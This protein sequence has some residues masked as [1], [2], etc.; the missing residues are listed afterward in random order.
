MHEDIQ[1][2]HRHWSIIVDPFSDASYSRSRH[3]LLE[4]PRPCKTGG[5]SVAGQK[6]P[7]WDYRQKEILSSADVTWTFEW[8]GQ[9]SILQWIEIYF[10]VQTRCLL[11]CIQSHLGYSEASG[12]AFR[13]PSRGPVWYLLLLCKSLKSPHFHFSAS[14]MAPNV[15]KWLKFSI[16]HH[17]SLNNQG[18]NQ[19]SN[20]GQF[21]E[22]LFTNKEISLSLQICPKGLSPLSH[23]PPAYR[24]F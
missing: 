11:L 17:R 3:I 24:Y 20:I 18:V 10:P 6:S 23:L 21:M 12:L 16:D 1:I 22:L 9:I 13:N 4:Y 14:R 7:I 15:G 8:V 19:L 2:H 5:Q